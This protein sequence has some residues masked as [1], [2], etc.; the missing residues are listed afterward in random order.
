MVGIEAHKSNRRVE[1]VVRTIRDGVRKLGDAMNLEEKIPV[2]TE[3]YNR[4][5]HIGIKCSSK[6]ALEETPFEAMI[7]TLKATLTEKDSENKKP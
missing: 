7:Q 2:I 1:K 5:Y 4:T 3:K 6:E